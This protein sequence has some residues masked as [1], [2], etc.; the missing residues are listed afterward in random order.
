[1]SEPDRTDA[2]ADAALAELA[3][4]P[5]GSPPIAA[6]LDAELAAL[7]PVRPRRPMRQLAIAL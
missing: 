2:A 6:A 5:P 4:Q 1:M 3:A 7:A